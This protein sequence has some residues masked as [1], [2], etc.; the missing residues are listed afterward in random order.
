MLL[1]HKIFVWYRA[2]TSTIVA[3]YKAQYVRNMCMAHIAL[4]L[5]KYAIALNALKRCRALYTQN[6]IAQYNAQYNAQ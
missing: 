3:P 5:G 2:Q 1:L 6:N 4:A